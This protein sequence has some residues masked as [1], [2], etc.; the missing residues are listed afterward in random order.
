[1]FIIIIFCC[2]CL[3]SVE[4]FFSNLNFILV[5]IIICSEIVCKNNKVVKIVLFIVCLNDL[6]M[7]LIKYFVLYI[8]NF[9]ICGVIFIKLKSCFVLYLLYLW[10]VFLGL[11]NLSYKK[12]IW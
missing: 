12:N 5:I 9:C 6:F 1:M 3:V 2:C 10:L 4:L 11:E 8:F 7:V